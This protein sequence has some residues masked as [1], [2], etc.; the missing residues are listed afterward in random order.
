M[1]RTKIGNLPQ[2]PDFLSEEEC[3]LRPRMVSGTAR[4]R[5]TCKSLGL[6]SSFAASEY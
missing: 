1:L 5:E 4:V 2:G 3:Y 6:L